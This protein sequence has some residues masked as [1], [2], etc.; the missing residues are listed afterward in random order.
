[1]NQKKN[2]NPY[3]IKFLTLYSQSQLSNR[4]TR[5]LD[6]FAEETYVETNLDKALKPQILAGNFRLVIITG[7]AGDGKTAFIQRMEKEIRPKAESFTQSPNGSSFSYQ[8][9]HFETNYDG[10][11]D[12]EDVQNDE[13]LLKFFK[14]FNGDKEPTE[15]IEIIKV[16]A[17]N[18]GRL[19]DF[20]KTHRREFRW[21]SKRIREFDETT[22]LSRNI[23]VVNLNLRSVV[24]ASIKEENQDSIFERVLKRFLHPHFWEACQ[25]CDYKNRCYVKFNVDSLNNPQICR[26]LE[27][28]YQIAYFRQKLHITMRDLRSSL[29]FIICNKYDCQNIQRDIEDNNKLIERFYYNSL[30]GFR[31][32][33]EE[34]EKDRVL[35]LLREV[36]PAEVG[37]PKLDNLFNFTQPKQIKGLA[38]IEGR[39]NFDA[40]LLSFF[41]DNR[42]VDVFDKDETKKQSAFIYHRTARRKYY[43]EGASQEEWKTLLPFTKLSDF[44]GAIDGEKD[45][46]ELRDII[47]EGISLS[48]RIYH[49]DTRKKSICVRTSANKR[50]LVKV[51]Y[52][53]G[54]DD[55]SC[56]TKSIG[57]IGKFIEY[58]P[59]NLMLKYIKRRGSMPLEINLD[60]F[61]MLSRIKFGYVPSVNEL[62]GYFLNLV[63]FKRILTTHLP[64]LIYLTEDDNKFYEISKDS[65]QNLLFTPVK[66]G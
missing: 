64:S 32:P 44:A 46:S 47:V 3:L 56:R 51:F 25:G 37:S 39:E 29:S 10:S 61:D 43:F 8:E 22:S 54:K 31:K 41:Y 57:E 4:G 48:E 33:E 6:K 35:K 66:G 30:F 58:V 63:M 53:F 16:I 26:R 28:F 17:I 65:S 14:P 49:S 42:P 9:L 45:L 11:Q 23:L 12:V 59:N 18:E 24:G 55:F 2:Y 40:E 60:L 15:P 7:N 34:G 19:R 52:G 36:D 21:L 5:G 62:K 20:L 27:I 13:V 50:P 1:M 38:G